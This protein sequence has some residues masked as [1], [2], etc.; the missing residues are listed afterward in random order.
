MNREKK[1]IST[2][3][4]IKLFYNDI[5]YVTRSLAKDSEEL[6]SHIAAHFR[7]E[8][9]DPQGIEAFMRDEEKRLKEAEDMFVE[10][11]QMEKRGRKKFHIKEWNSFEKLKSVVMELE[12]ITENLKP[13]SMWFS[14]AN[15]DTIQDMLDEVQTK[16]ED[17]IKS[18]KRVFK[19]W[20]EDV[21]QAHNIRFTIEYVDML[22]GAMKYLNAN[23]W[24]YRKHLKSLFIED[25][26]LYCDEEIKLLKKNVAIMTDNDNWLF[27]KQR[28][29]KEVL[30]ENYIGKETEFNQIRKNYDIFYSWLLTL[31]EEVEFSPEDFAE[32]CNFLQELRRLDYHV[33]YK[34]LV[35]NVPFFTKEMVYKLTFSDIVK[36]IRDYRYA[37]KVIKDKCGISYL[38]DI[39]ENL[40]YDKWGKMIQRVLEKQNWLTEKKEQIDYYFGGIYSGTSTDWE[41]MKECIL[42]STSEINGVPERRIKQYQFTVWKEPEAEELAESVEQAAEWILKEETSIMV[43]DFIKKCS[44]ILGHKRITAKFKQ[45]MESYFQDSLPEEYKIENDFILIKDESKLCF[46]IAAD[47]KK[48][49]VESISINEWKN[50]ILSVIHVEQEI[51]L[52]DL[53]KLFA[54]LLGYP[55]RTRVLQQKVEDVVK[56]LKQDNRI[57]RHSGGW[58]LIEI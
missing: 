48:R 13:S 50:G 41:L 57:E 34:M 58:S 7:W 53:T 9:R 46:R 15:Y 6:F 45:E 42:E 28:K 47:K 22:N 29:I 24:K 21:L 4:E 54:K 36:Q 31:P 33:Y 19:L 3:E 1:P 51:T 39:K 14:K 8:R 17:S 5:K 27:F 11:M 16:T 43:S 23:F 30:G 25:P 56:L 20:K 10:L 49:D 37:L 52:D 38:H 32:Y 44:K 40:T 26:S 55:R 12:G 2:L 18:S 35:E